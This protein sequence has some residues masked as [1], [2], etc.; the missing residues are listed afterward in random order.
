VGTGFKNLRTQWRRI[1]VVTLL[2]AVSGYLI[3][4]RIPLELAGVPVAITAAALYAVVVGGTMF[5]AVI[6]LP[7]ITIAMEA[8]AVSRLAYAAAVAAF[9]DFGLI[10]L[11]SPLLGAT[12]VVVGGTLLLPTF[13]HFQKVRA[14]QAYIGSISPSARAA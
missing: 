2:A 8:F 7:S 1:L 10:A 11:Q 6:F 14:T 9:P 4:F 3:Y 13:R 12:I 5:S